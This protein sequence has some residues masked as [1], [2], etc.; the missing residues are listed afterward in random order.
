MC[1]CKIDSKL[2]DD[3]RS[4]VNENWWGYYKYRCY[5][6]VNQWNCLCS[7]MDWISVSVS[8]L[9]SDNILELT[10]DENKNSVTVYTFISGIDMCGNQFNNC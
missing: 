3:F 5:K 8:Y 7:A 6:G 1:E 4:V 10:K 9:S 2:I